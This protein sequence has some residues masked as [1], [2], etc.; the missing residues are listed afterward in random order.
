M[1]DHLLKLVGTGTVVATAAAYW[2]L[3]KPALFNPTVD[4][5]SQTTDALVGFQ[6]SLTNLFSYITLFIL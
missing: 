6:S 1:D 4:Y 2:M 3:K 5:S